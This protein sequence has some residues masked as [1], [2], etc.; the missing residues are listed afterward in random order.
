MSFGNIAVFDW[1]RYNEHEPGERDVFS[2][3]SGKNRRKTGGFRYAE[4]RL[5]EGD[6]I[7]DIIQDTADCN[8]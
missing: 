1:I 4:N 6:D 8:K 7:E 2:F 5:R 3:G